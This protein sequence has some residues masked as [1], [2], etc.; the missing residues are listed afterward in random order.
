[1]SVSTQT[2]RSQ[3]EFPFQDTS[4][5]VERRLD[6][7]ISRLTLDE[8]IA[9][10]ATKCAV[11]RLGV[12]GAMF[13]EGLHGLCQSGPAEWQ[14]TGE[15]ATPTTTF[16]QS[17][18]MGHTW[19]P[20]L[21]RETA[22]AQARECRY[23]FHHPDYLG[24][25]L[26]VLAPNADLGRDPRWGRTEECFGEDA[27]L[28]G[29]LA[30]E[31]VKGLQGDDPDN[32]VCASLMKHFLANSHEHLR[33][34]T[35]SDFD[36][37]MLREYYSVP[38]RRGIQEGG[39]RAYMA[40]YNGVNG[41]PGCVHP[42][43][44]EISM[45]EWGQ[46]GIICTDGNAL[47]LLISDHKTYETL[48]EGAAESIKAGMTVFLD[49]FDKPVREA[50]AEGRLDEG[51]L[52]EAIRR[53]FRVLAKLDL[54]DPPGTGRW[55]CIGEGSPPWK[56]VAHQELAKRATDQSLVLLKND[57]MLPL[58]PGSL[59][60]V[61]VV[62]RW[63]D[64]VLPDWYSGVPPYAVTPLEGI[65]AAIPNAAVTYCDGSD[66]AE[67]VL[68]AAQAD[69][70][71]GVFGNHPTGNAGWAKVERAS[72]GKES[73][74]RQSL[75]LEDEVLL[76]KLFAVNPKTLLVLQS[77]FPYAINWSQDNIPAI[78]FVTHCSQETGSA[79][80]DAI[81]GVTN[82]GG[83]L[84][85]TW[86]KGIDDLPPLMDYDLRNGRT[87]M[88]SK[89]EP[90]YEFGFGLSYTLFELGS[91]SV[92]VEGTKVR[93]SV[94]VS[95]TGSRDGDEVV[96]LYVRYPASLVTRPQLELKAFERVSV[97]VG[98]TVSVELEFDKQDLAYW[99]ESGWVLENGLVELVVGTSS[100]KIAHCVSVEV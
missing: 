17:Y 10:L 26:V 49:K 95:N 30:V 73:V 36:E 43:H 11:P 93:A 92:S 46:D 56:S 91:L 75:V 23:I 44:R 90:L 85:Q 76:K 19:N 13:V 69:V 61:L 94:P 100:R 59:K 54:L 38:F 28:V 31:V 72:D 89:A 51:D 35:S 79:L 34:S 33:E 37:R 86:P 41:P 84:T 81:F 63:A 47:N 16:P 98:E 71:I 27:F 53:T 74:D 22:A 83:K 42:M 9:C 77:S 29:T 80:A 55:E 88:Y 8:K 64:S 60:S 2:P 1:M 21:V 15:R 12:R 40:C 70:V 87:Y 20:A 52:D 18:G 3:Q 7:L 24:A 62:G 32:W 6:D 39:S 5:P 65:R 68:L 48:A 57:G 50:L 96:Q 97:P 67:A 58:D 78:L 25:G 82:P 4:L 14:P 99:G 66:E 45:A